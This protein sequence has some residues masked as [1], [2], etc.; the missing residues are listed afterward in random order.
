[1]DDAC[2]LLRPCA[3]GSRSVQVI[4]YDRI[5]VMGGGALL[6]SGTPSTLLE[7]PH[8]ALRRMAEALG[9]E[10]E[11]ALRERAK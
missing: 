11:A 10:A 9:A 8:S 3:A 1:M 7:T 5:L 6:E 4:D 2:H